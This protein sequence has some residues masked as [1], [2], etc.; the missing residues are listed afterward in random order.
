MVPLIAA[1][2]CHGAA[3]MMASFA[4]AVQGEGSATASSEGKS[5]FGAEDFQRMK[6][7]L[8]NRFF[9]NADP[10]GLAV[11]I[12]V[13]E[14]EGEGSSDSEE[15]F[16]SM[17]R[18]SALLQ[19]ETREMNPYYGPGVFI[20]LAMPNRLPSE[21]DGYRIAAR[22]NE[23]EMLG[24]CEAYHYGAWCFTRNTLHYVAFLPNQMK[25]DGSTLMNLGLYQMARARWAYGKINELLAANS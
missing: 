11:N 15:A 9:C 18:N 23:L 12:P 19:L 2:A 10:T 4:K 22:L 5:A 25:G 17:M 13:A 1:A 24:E 16:H 14:S 20:R 7:F 3:S 21:D 8:G 6:S